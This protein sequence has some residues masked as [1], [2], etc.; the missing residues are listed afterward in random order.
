MKWINANKRLP[1][2]KD[3]IVCIRY[4][5]GGAYYYE[6]G[7][8]ASILHQVKIMEEGIMKYDVEWLDESDEMVVRIS[9]LED[10]ISGLEA[11]IKQIDSRTSGLIVYG[12]N[13]SLI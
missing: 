2:N 13:S 4:D 1:E 11:Y 3:D 7:D 10:K 6:A 12:N 5:G 9:K 8:T